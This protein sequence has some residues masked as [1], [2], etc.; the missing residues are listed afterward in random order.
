MSISLDVFE[1]F[2]VRGFNQMQQQ[3][4]P[5][6]GSCPLYN[7]QG[8][9]DIRT[10]DVV[11]KERLGMRRFQTEDMVLILTRVKNTKTGERCYFYSVDT[12]SA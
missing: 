5:V 12:F 3:P 2:M 10:A 9:S 4:F 6:C 1:R 11:K 8:F 7:L